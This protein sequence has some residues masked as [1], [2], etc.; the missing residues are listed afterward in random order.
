[1]IRE[2]ELETIELPAGY[3][4]KDCIYD[5]SE[6][7]V[8]NGVIRLL[9]YY[10]V[11]EHDTSY[12]M[13]HVHFSTCN[14][15]INTK[16][17][18]PVS[19]ID[20]KKL[21][22]FVPEGF[23]FFI[24]SETKRLHFFQNILKLTMDKMP[25]Y[26]MYAIHSGYN[27]LPNNEYVYDLG[28]MVLNQSEHIL[29][30]NTPSS[31]IRDF[32]HVGSHYTTWI[33]NFFQQS[34]NHPALFIAAT[35]SLIKPLLVASGI[36]TIF[37]LYLVGE[38]G[39]GKSEYAKLLTDI[40]QEHDNCRSLSSSQKDLFSRMGRHNDFLFLIDDL[41]KTESA[42]VKDKKEAILSE[43]IQLISSG[44]ST[45]YRG[46]LLQI[47]TM[48]L[49]TA[50]YALKNHSSINRCLLVELSDNFNAEKLT[51][52]QNHHGL[53]INFLAEYIT[54][55]C[56]QHTS[57]TGYISS[58]EPNLISFS[59]E[60]SQA[61]AG[62]ARIHRTYKILRIASELYLQFLKEHLRFSEPLLNGLRKQILAS[63][64]NCISFTLESV[65]KADSDGGTHYL[66]PI[67]EAFLHNI[68]HCVANSYEE[69]REANR[70]RGK[71]RFEKAKKP[72]EDKKE[73]L[74]FRE[75]NLYYCITGDDLVEF[76]HKRD[77][78]PYII[79]KKAISAQLKYHGL[80]KCRG[81]EYTFPLN[82]N[83]SKTRYYH[84]YITRITE[85]SQE[86][87]SKDDLYLASFTS[88]LPEFNSY[89]NR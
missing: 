44:G 81:G 46:E 36:N 7:Q 87:F 61:Y 27:Q 6:R 5:D 39:R 68:H 71:K 24:D 17:E 21:L 26:E 76:F 15:F 86:Y 69:Y 59:V 89:V 31:K 57:L 40:F 74:F 14:G 23:L 64:D 43:V 55:L 75:Q 4:E 19:V 72:T 37:A 22:R 77:N 78:F 79:S 32:S 3:I 9:G 12:Y 53:Y 34:E 1:M 83:R 47:N 58:W 85:L 51:W 65:K 13:L 48:P 84:L 73:K 28:G 29:L 10:K 88:P 20:S 16:I 33:R 45:E 66:I 35:V 42:R 30:K 18:I 80:L 54:W 82:G 67:L 62:I 41:N 49:I 63:V 2:N 38:T 25:I 60:D 11:L 8:T 50:E 70:P 52:L 56:Q